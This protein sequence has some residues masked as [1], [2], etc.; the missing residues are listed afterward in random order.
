MRIEKSLSLL[1]LSV[2]A[3]AVFVAVGSSAA[4]AEDQPADDQPADLK[5]QIIR[6]DDAPADVAD[7]GEIRRYFTGKTHAT[8]DVLVAVA[9]IEPGKTIHKTHRHANEE[10]LAVVKGSGTW[11]LKDKESPAKPGDILYVA[12]WVYHGITNTGDTPLIFL[13]IRYNGKGLPVPPQPDDR[14]NELK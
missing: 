9:V 3:V 11:T 6:F 7:W 1:W 10:Y 8:K 13:V 2:V 14:P 4:A 12:P 5:S